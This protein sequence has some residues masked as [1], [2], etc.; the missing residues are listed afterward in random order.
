MNRVELS[1]K[2]VGQPVVREL[3]NK[4]VLSFSVAV[5]ER[6]GKNGQEK[7]IVSFFDVES[8][9][10]L[11]LKKGDVIVIEGSLRQDRWESSD[12][13][14]R[15]KVKILAWKITKVEK[16]AEKKTEPQIPE[17]PV[18]QPEKKQATQPAKQP[19][20]PQKAYKKAKKPF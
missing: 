12:G 11:E 20:Q 6:Y 9:T 16:T 13:G 4:K 17:K 5:S 15:S 10:D 19:T 8:F 2:V 3:G 14:K 1:G 18:K 7:E